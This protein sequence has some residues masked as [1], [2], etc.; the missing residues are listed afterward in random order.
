MRSL[1]AASRMLAPRSMPWRRR[2]S[3]CGVRGARGVHAVCRARS[4]RQATY[5]RRAGRARR[6][7]GRRTPAR[8]LR[9]A[10]PCARCFRQVF[11]DNRSQRLLACSGVCLVTAPRRPLPRPDFRRLAHSRVRARLRRCACAQ[12]VSVPGLDNVYQRPPPTFMHLHVVT[13]PLTR[14]PRPLLAQVQR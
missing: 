2:R 13:H 14:S 1:A 10:G 5:S 9:A 12:P 4:P 7:R 6:E 3:L 11:A 8:L